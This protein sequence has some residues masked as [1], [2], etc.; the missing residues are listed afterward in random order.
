VI[1][2]L[3]FLALWLALLILA[4][5]A[6]VKAPLGYEDETGF[7]AVNFNHKIYVKRNYTLRQ[8]Y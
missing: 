5:W 6:V 7:N 2:I 1:V 4:A 8:I 3:S